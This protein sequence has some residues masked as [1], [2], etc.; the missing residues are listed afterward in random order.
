MMQIF[1][2]VQDTNDANIL[3][4]KIPMMQIFLKC[5][6]PMMQI[7]FKRKISMMQIFLKLCY[8]ADKERQITAVPVAVLQQPSM[9]CS[10]F[11]RT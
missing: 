11:L 3:K 7:F 10:L 6:I 4:R 2:Q 1:S 9:L 8:S 5:K